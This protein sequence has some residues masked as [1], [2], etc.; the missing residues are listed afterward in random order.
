MIDKKGNEIVKVDSIELR[1]YQIPIFDAIFNKKIPKVLAVLSRRAG[2]DITALYCILYQLL[3]KTCKIYYLFPNYNSAR[4]SAF[5]NIRQDG[6]RFID[7][8]PKELVQSINISEMK[9]T[10]NNGSILQFI[11]GSDP[12]KLRGV[13]LQAVVYSEFAFFDDQSVRSVLRPV[14]AATPDSWELIVTTPNGR[15]HLYDIYKAALRSDEWFVYHKG[16]NELKHIPYET[17]YQDVEEGLMTEEVFRA[18]YLCEFV[19]VQGGVYS[20]I[21]NTIRNSGKIGLYPYD[22][23]EGNLYSVWDFGFNDDTAILIVQKVGS[24][25]RIVDSYSNSR[26]PLTHYIS[27]IKSLNL[28]FD[29]HFAP[30]DSKQHS[31]ST[32][33]TRIEVAARLGI[34]FQ[35][36]PKTSIIEGVNIA[37]LALASKIFINEEPNKKFITALENYSQKWDDKAKIYTKDFF[38]SKHSHFA[39]AFRYLCQSIDKMGNDSS[40]EEL[41]SRYRKAMHGGTIQSLNSDF[42]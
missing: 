5:D 4:K 12:S 38:H 10:L 23:G 6:V 18:E 24:S 3:K 42:F 26:E 16:L 40:P 36:V 14:L 34:H 25:I 33:I 21:M 32:G 8:I 30:H 20:K 17:A 41:D 19:A 9:I 22:A 27:Y 29:G 31:Y 39:D 7:F 15:N 28:P 1:D 2:K 13:Q 35:V 37:K 11:G